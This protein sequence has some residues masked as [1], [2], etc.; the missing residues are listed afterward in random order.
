MS[1]LDEVR[2]GQLAPGR[3]VLQQNLDD[4]K[5]AEAGVRVAALGGVESKRDLFDALREPLRCPSWFGSNWDAL[6]DWLTDDVWL[7]SSQPTILL[8]AHLNRAIERCPS[9]SLR[10]LAILDEA[11]QFWSGR[12]RIVYVVTD[13]EIDH[14][15]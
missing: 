15:G 12:G 10:L 9:D 14:P 6:W 7:D 2:Y 3:W 1:G 13:E 5:A 11:V 4:F 8:L